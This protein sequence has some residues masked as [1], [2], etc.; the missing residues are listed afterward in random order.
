MIAAGFYAVV[1][2]AFGLALTGHELLGLAVSVLGIA[3]LA[4]VEHVRG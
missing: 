4:V 3:A 2:A 1:F